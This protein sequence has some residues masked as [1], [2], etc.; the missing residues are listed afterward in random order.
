MASTSE[1]E[2]EEV[3]ACGVCDIE[4]EERT[5]AIVCQTCRQWV[6]LRKCANLTGKE[7]SKI[8]KSKRKKFKCSRCEKKALK[9]KRANAES[10]KRKPI[11]NIKSYVGISSSGEEET[12]QEK[13]NESETD[14]EKSSQ[15][16]TDLEKSSEEETD[17]EKSS[18]EETDGEKASEEEI[19]EKKSSEKE[20]DRKK[21]SEEESNEKNSSEEGIDERNLDEDEIYGKKSSEEEIESQV[22]P[23]EDDVAEDARMDF[24]IDEG[25]GM[26]SGNAQCATSGRKRRSNPDSWKS[27]KKRKYTKGSEGKALR[28]SCKC[29]QG[30]AKKI[31][32]PTRERIMQEYW[33]L[34][35]LDRQRD[36]HVRFVKLVPTARW[37]VRKTL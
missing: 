17:G 27:N 19:A 4:M 1:A 18:E 23:Q 8:K 9:E 31:D 15:E 16:E 2:E 3:W 32:T 34:K 35:S 37:R 20:A 36:F 11:K 14:I 5:P 6:H 24:Y 10:S 21:S 30:C 12:D 25:D 7:A 29:K 22:V 13:T 33:D 28:E 26:M